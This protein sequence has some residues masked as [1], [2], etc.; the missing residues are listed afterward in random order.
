MP[1]FTRRKKQKFIKEEIIYNDDRAFLKV[2]RIR[3][4]AEL[5][6]CLTWMPKKEQVIQKICMDKEDATKL[7]TA[8]LKMIV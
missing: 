8:I 5:T 4:W 2:R 3:G 6:L 7:A 1:G